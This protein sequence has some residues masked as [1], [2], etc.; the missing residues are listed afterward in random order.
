MAFTQLSKALHSKLYK[1]V[2][3]QSLQRCLLIHANRAVSTVS[4]G[5]TYRKAGAPPC[6]VPV[7][8]CLMQTDRRRCI[9]FTTSA[10]N[11]S[12]PEEKDKSIYRYEG[13]SPKPSTAQKGRQNQNQNHWCLINLP[14]K[15]C[16]LLLIKHNRSSS[17]QLFFFLNSLY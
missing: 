7:M 3:Q 1:I 4:S 13:G 16:C 10:R 15:Y 8:S 2:T 9:S 6:L 5:L 14:I 12:S 11:K 17:M